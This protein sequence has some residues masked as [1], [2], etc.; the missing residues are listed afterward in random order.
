MRRCVTLFLIANAGL[1]SPSGAQS[2]ADAVRKLDSAWAKSYAT[3]DTVVARQIFAPDLI[4][5]AT[6]GSLKNRE[7]EVADVRPYPGM[8]VNYF[9]SSDVQ[10]RCQGD[11]CAVIGLLSWETV[12]NGRASPLR[13]RYTATYARGGPLGWQMIALHIGQAPPQ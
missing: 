13:R 2:P 1:A 4:V 11:A 3:H 6:N 9:R 5:T 7:G 8:T 12:S 10:V